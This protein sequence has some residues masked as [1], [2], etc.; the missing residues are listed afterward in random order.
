MARRKFSRTGGR[1]PGY[2]VSPD[3]F[4]TVLRIPAPDW[5]EKIP[6]IILPNQEPVFAK[7]FGNG[8]VRLGT[9]GFFRPFLKT[10]VAPF[11][12]PPTD[13][14]WVSEDA[15]RQNSLQNF[16]DQSLWLDW[17]SDH[18]RRSRH[19]MTSI[20]RLYSNHKL[21]STNQHASFTLF[22]VYH[23]VPVANVGILVLFFFLPIALPPLIGE[24]K[25]L[26]IECC[27]LRA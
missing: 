15:T 25:S 9:Q 14:P 3:H 8:P 16:V 1:T 7:P 12:P 13:C 18:V 2:Q 10:F 11:R 27:S 24:N 6:C 5:A 22:I 4:Q 21:R 20:L 19:S 23:R 26:N 17:D